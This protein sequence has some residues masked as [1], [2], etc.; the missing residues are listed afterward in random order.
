ML[1][2]CKVEDQWLK[3]R[4]PR[5]ILRTRSRHAGIVL[6]DFMDDRWIISIPQSG[7][8]II[9]DAREDPPKLCKW[10]SNF[11]RGG[12]KNALV[13]VDPHQ[14]DMIIAAWE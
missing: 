6:L 12:T 5:V 4:D 2:S 9:W 8:P 11:L 7:P 3:R 10:T 13:T 14:G 1:D